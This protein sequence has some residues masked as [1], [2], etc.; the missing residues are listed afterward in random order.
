MITKK[1]NWGFDA[2]APNGLPDGA[3][4]RYY[5][6]DLIRDLQYMM[7]RLGL[8]FKDIKEIVPFIVSGGVVTQGAGTTLNTTSGVGYVSKSVQNVLNYGVTP[9]T[10]Q[11]E[12]IE[13][14]RVV[15][16]AQ[17]N[18]AL[19]VYTPGGAINYVK[20][21]YTDLDGTLRARAK[22]AGNWSYDSSPSFTILVSAAAPTAYELVLDS[23]TEGGGTFTFSGKKSSGGR[24][25]IAST[26][27]QLNNSEYKVSHTDRVVLTLPVTASVGECIKIQDIGSRGWRVNQNAGQNI[28][29]YN[30]STVPGVT[31]YIQSKTGYASIELECVVAN[32]TWIAKNIRDMWQMKGYI[33]GGNAGGM[34]A[35]IE[36]LN[37]ATESS[38]PIAATLDTAKYLGTGVSSNLKGY[39][40]GGNTGAVTAV[41]ED[42]NFATESSVSIAATLNTAKSLGTGVS[43]NLKG[44]ILGGNIGA[45]TAVIEDLNFATESSVPIAATLDTAK[46]LGAGVQGYN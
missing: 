12:D 7:D 21:S 34:V 10:T 19:P 23:F 28:L 14:I 20:V 40:L 41:I 25:T 32:T 42:L 4:D 35:V 24:Y 36:D 44:Y 27:Y 9:P 33:L 6:Q 30:Q 45:A 8:I 31:G 22:K 18:L 1:I 38:V 29:I 16:T 26:P 3:G 39:I 5:A 43:S 2:V 15:W 46:D 17:T 11:N 13:A 37:F